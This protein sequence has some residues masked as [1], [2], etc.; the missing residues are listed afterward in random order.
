MCFLHLNMAI[1]QILQ[2]RDLILGFIFK[3][4]LEAIKFYIVISGVTYK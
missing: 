2:V 1:I 4:F 3:L